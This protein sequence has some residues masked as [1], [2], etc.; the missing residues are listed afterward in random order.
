MLNRKSALAALLAFLPIPAF[1]QTTKVFIDQDTSGPGGT[2][3]ISI[4]MLLKAPNVEV[5]GIGVIAGDA[6]LDQA[7][8][9]TLK[10]AEVSGKPN[11]PVAA[12]AAEPLLQ[13]GDSMKMRHALWGPK[14]GDG[15]Y[16]NWGKLVPPSGTI[17]PAPGGP[18]SIKPVPMHAAELLIEMARKY[19]GELVLYTA[20]PMTNVALAVKLAPDIVPKIKKVYTMGGAIHVNEKF[21]FWWDAEAAGIHMR[22]DWNERELTPIDVCHKTFVRQELIDAVAKADTPLARYVKEAYASG[23]EDLFNFM[24]DELAAAAIIDPSIITKTEELFVDVDWGFGPNYGKTVWWR[25]DQGGPSWA[26][27]TWRVQTD[28]DVARFEKLYV[29]LL[30]RP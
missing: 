5:V 23:N 17:P 30:S 24:W 6:W 14:P 3:S 16:G 13:T 21:N 22:T 7:L 2:D 12:G 25:K 9:H 20:G 15:W 18:P 26:K 11:V 8:Y 10:I 1:A 4:A 28:I 29:E 19:P 27:K